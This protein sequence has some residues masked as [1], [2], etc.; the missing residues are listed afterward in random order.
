MWTGLPDGTVALGR[1][2]QPAAGDLPGGLREESPNLTLLLPLRL[3]LVP[4]MDPTQVDAH[5]AGPPRH[6]AS[7]GGMESEL[8]ANSRDL[9]PSC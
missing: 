1:G 5:I 6:R 2:V 9:A 8:G 4:P 7:G 3:L